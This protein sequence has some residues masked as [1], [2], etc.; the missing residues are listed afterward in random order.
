[1]SAAPVPPF[2]DPSDPDL[3]GALNRLATGFLPGLIGLQ[4]TGAE[5]GR[6][7]ARLPI[8]SDHLAPNGFLHAATV[9]ALADSCCGYGCRMALPEGAAGFTT[10][11]L[12]SNFLRTLTEGT[13]AAT[14][15]LVHGGRTTQVWDAE[16]TDA[17][18]GRVLAL[19]R[20][21]Q[22]VLWPR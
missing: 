10:I 2:P 9:I 16:V 18:D 13:L 21:T 4:V 15:R 11:E 20:C 22:A 6:V 8:R 5:P 3:V 19:F 1:L 14:A 7:E 17:A 12:K